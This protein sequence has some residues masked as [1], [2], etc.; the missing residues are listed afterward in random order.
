MG[1]P[2]VVS[3]VEEE[4]NFFFLFFFLLMMAKKK[5]SKIKYCLYPPHFDR[6]NPMGL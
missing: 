4:R 6:H 1:N 2:S 5:L 3:G